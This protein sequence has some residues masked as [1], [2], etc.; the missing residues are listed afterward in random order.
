M[1]GR[2]WAM[3]SKVRA[4]GILALNSGLVFSSS[5]L[6]SLMLS[7]AGLSKWMDLRRK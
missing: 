4:L 7:R 6:P 3:I 1:I 5:Y 2:T